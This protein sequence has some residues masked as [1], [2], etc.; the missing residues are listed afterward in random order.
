MKA[1]ILTA[2][3]AAFLVDLAQRNHPVALLQLW[4]SIRPLVIL[5]AK[6]LTAKRPDLEPE[7]FIQEAY[8]GF[9]DAVKYFRPGKSQF[10]SFAMLCIR[11]SLKR[12]MGTRIYNDFNFFQ[13]HRA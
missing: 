5:E 1:K 9:A 13:K 3:Q 12:K 7:D 4:E 8:F 10:T 6:K 11:R 2:A